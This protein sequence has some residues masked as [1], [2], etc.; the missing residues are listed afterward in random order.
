[1]VF[2]LVDKDLH[3]NQTVN[4]E[5]LNRSSRWLVNNMNPN[6]LP[7]EDIFDSDFVDE[8]KVLYNYKI[9]NN[10]NGTVRTVPKSN[11]KNVEK[12]KIIKPLT[13]KYITVHFHGLGQALQ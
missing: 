1:M 12:G 2:K 6:D 3:K 9:K 10:L 11:R 13:D 8:F 7:F 4:Q 5:T